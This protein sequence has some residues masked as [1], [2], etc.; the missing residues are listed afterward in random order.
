MEDK[1]LN[2]WKRFWGV[3]VKPVPTFQAIGKN[4]R[5]LVPALVIIAINVLL[6]LLIIPESI[7]FTESIWESTGQTMPPE[8][9][10]TAITASKVSIILAA[11]LLPPL[12]WL[13]QAILLSV[14]K[15]FTVGEA[16]FKELYAVSLFAWL[17]PFLGGAID[18]LLIKVVGFDSALAVQTSL[19]LFLP[20][21]I[22]S[23]FWFVMLSKMDFFVIWG[24]VLLSLGGA[25]VMKRDPRKVGI[26]VF[27]AW[28]I[29]VIG[30][31]YISAQFAGITGM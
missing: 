28:L 2:I 13:V 10:N 25:T 22:E 11:A 4:P 27:A 1:Q 14:V 7:A 18:S 9:Y 8:A 12:I 17:P 29:Y 6:A 24:L 30:L 19:A 20:S 16:S 3:I 15:Q 23:G 5:I 26:Y 31:A 21:S